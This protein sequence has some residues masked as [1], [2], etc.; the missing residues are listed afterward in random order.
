MITVHAL[1]Y[2]ECKECAVCARGMYAIVLYWEY[3]YLHVH[4]RMI[5]ALY[6]YHYTCIVHEYK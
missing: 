1:V 3:M 5:H 6:M 4:V 2:M